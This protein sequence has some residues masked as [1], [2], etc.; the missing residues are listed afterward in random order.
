MEVTIWE[1]KGRFLGWHRSLHRMIRH[2]AIILLSVLWLSPCLNAQEVNKLVPEFVELDF[3]DA[4]EYVIG[5]VNIRGA[6][7]RDDNAIKSIVGL[8]EGNTITI[9]GDQLSEGV[10][11][12]WRLRLF[13]DVSIL[14]DSIVNDELYLTVDLKEQPVLTR[15]SFRGL[16]KG[17]QEK[18]SELLE[19]TL[20]VGGIVS[21]N[22]KTV[23]KNLIRDD[24][25]DKGYLDARVFIIE[26]IDTTRENASI[27]EFEIDEGEKI[28]IEDVSFIGN[29]AVSDKK[30]RKLMK[31]TKRKQAFLKK[32]RFSN[33]TFEDDKKKIIDHY[34]KIGHSDAIIV[35]D[36]MWRDETGR[37]FLQVEVSEG[38]Q[39][40]FGNITWKGNSIY[41]V[42]WQG[43]FFHL[44]RQWISV[45]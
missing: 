21:E 3:G 44:S 15:Y 5:G 12:L 26:T 27:I 43:Y 18:L 13:S 6:E 1:L 8:R 33:E 22:D 16:K 29:E 17:K 4:K 24:F 25:I 35:S 31:E 7:R 10:R 14:L 38:A 34:I 32:S 20:R 39:Y 30:L 23:S 9:P 2:S 36:S 45:L 37:V 11:K 40:K 42:R 19:G 41:P 28:K